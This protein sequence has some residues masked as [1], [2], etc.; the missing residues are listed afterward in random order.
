MIPWRMLLASALWITIASADSAEGGLSALSDKERLGF[1]T[2]LIHTNGAAANPATSPRILGQILLV[3]VAAE[4][5]SATEITRL[6][7][8]YCE[9]GRLP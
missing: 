9:D 6:H 7:E 3:I 8:R 4:E 1:A 2:P 5:E